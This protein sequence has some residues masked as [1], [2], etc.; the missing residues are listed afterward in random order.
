MYVEYLM[1]EWLDSDE[2]RRIA[3]YS[4]TPLTIIIAAIH[5][6]NQRGDY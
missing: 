1:L 3:S 2:L 5:I 6:L 4:A